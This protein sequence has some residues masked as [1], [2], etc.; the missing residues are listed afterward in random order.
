MRAGRP[1]SQGMV[2]AAF[3]AMRMTVSRDH[4]ETRFPHPPACGKARAQPVR[5]G[6]GKPGLPLPRPVGGSGKAQPSQ[7]HPMVIPSG[8]DAS[9]MDGCA[10]L[11][12][13]TV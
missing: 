2:I 12:Q 8:C 1:R 11:R 13:N 7:E 3:C 9:R 5:R 10:G 4:G 6:T